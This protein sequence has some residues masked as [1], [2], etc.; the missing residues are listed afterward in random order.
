ML[1]RVIVPLLIGLAL[2]TALAACGPAMSS[3][4]GD[5]ETETGEEA[6][7]AS[8]NGGDDGE[9]D[10]F[11]SLDEEETEAND[12]PATDEE[13]AGD[14][15]AETSF[16]VQADSAQ[17]DESGIEVGFTEAGRPYRGAAAAPVVLK[18]FS[19]YQCPFCARFS[20]Q[21]M[22]GLLENQVAAGEVVVIFHDFP[23]TSIHPQAM[24]ASHA[25]RCA[26][27]QGAAAYWAMHDRLFA[28]Q[29]EWGNDQAAQLF[30]QYAADLGLDVAQFEACQEEE[31][32]IGEIETDLA[33]GQEQGVR[34]TP[35]FFVND[36]ILVGAQSLETFNQAIAAVQEG[37]EIAAQP[38]AEPEAEEPMVAPTPAAIPVAS[39]NVAGAIGDPEAP[40]TIVEY[41]D[42]QCPYC[43]RHSQQTLPQIIENLVENGRVYYVLKDFPLDNLHPQ[44]RSA[45]AAARCAG[46]QDAYWEMH[47]ALF[48]SQSEWGQ[49]G[50]ATAVYTSQAETLG[51]DTSAFTECLESNKYLNAIQA[52]LEEG[53]SL[54]VR[55]TPAFF[56]DG[57]PVSGAQPFELFQYA[58]DLAEEGA[59]AEAYERPPEPTPVPTPSGPVDVDITGSF[60]TGD[61]EAPVTI[62]EFSDYQCPFCARHFSQT[63]PQIE[64]NYIDEGLVYYVF[65]DFPLTNIH[66]Q[67]VLAAEAARCAGDQGEYV[68]MHDELFAQQEAWSGRDDAAAL[69]ADYAAELDLDVEAFTA[70]LESDRHEAAV[71]ADLEQG[72]ELGVRGTPAF[73]VNGRFL[74]GAQPYNAF[75]Q[76]IERALSETE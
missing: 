70:C 58:V 52:N 57:Y 18:E 38:D 27:E 24:L 71:Q 56:I 50:D 48:D 32:Y 41:T 61:P 39:E 20:N 30:S 14:A 55:G 4:N 3:E 66:P 23:L 5:A 62:V 21:T 11:E 53:Q 1:K 69:F 64:Q 17:V 2:L 35:T 51:L 47:D 12:E 42:Y 65:K 54:G 13:P 37:E 44:A 45:A 22:P 31:R 43:S 73:F 72:V 16:A 74:N 33:V 7:A 8:E 49:A 25:A 40:V 36:Q 75:E 10:V 60:A 9:G 68:A 6:I 63:M 46:E 28:D 34:S 76:A 59:L 26:G 29:N 67:A 19:D 15:E